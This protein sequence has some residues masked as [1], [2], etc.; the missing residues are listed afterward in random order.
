MYYKMHKIIY[1]YL[2]LVTFIIFLCILFLNVLNGIKYIKK[3]KNN[4]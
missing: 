4:Q 2:L 3:F 1:N